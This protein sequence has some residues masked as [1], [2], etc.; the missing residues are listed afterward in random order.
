MKTCVGLGLI[1]TIMVACGTEGGENAAI[2]PKAAAIVGTWKLLSGTVIEKGDTTRTDYTQDIS[3][4]K[5]INDTH[6]A[7]MKH[8]LN[9]GADTAIYV[10]GG[11]AYSLTDSVYTEHL[12]YCSAREWEGHDF[13]FTVELKGDTL[14]QRGVEVV[15]SAGVNR[16]NVETYIRLKK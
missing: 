10:S 15:E 9:K 12:E 7:F 16:Q 13:T 3:F 6:F 2:T 14:V 1:C 11:G 4:I 8:D 5:V